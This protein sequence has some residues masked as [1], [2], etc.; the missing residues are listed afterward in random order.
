MN[1]QKYNV[2]GG[3][4]KSFVQ[5]FKEHM[6][7][8]V[9]SIIVIDTLMSHV[10]P[11]GEMPV[12]FV[13]M[14][15]GNWFLV[16]WTDRKKRCHP[17][18]LYPHKKKEMLL[19]GSWS[20]QT[21]TYRELYK[22]VFQRLRQLDDFPT[23]V[24]STNNWER[25]RQA[26]FTCAKLLEKSVQ[27]RVKMKEQLLL[28]S[29]MSHNYELLKSTCTTLGYETDASELVKRVMNMYDKDLVFESEKVIRESGILN[30][31]KEH[32]LSKWNI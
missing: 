1:L 30:L 6:D 20:K 32:V 11:V 27:E 9:K 5:K 21:W 10:E 25:N 16:G 22:C 3:D 7:V 14:E 17:Q 23:V 19:Y 12:G 29:I 13:L 28:K 18:N 15:S 26:L 24:A 8:D 2:E 4:K 31:L